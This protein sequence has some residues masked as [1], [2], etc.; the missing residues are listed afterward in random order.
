MDH[1]EAIIAASAALFIALIVAATPGLKS[2]LSAWLKRWENKLIQSSAKRAYRNGIERLA[3]FHTV[4]EQIR[5]L[6]W[7]DRVLVMVGKN[8]GGTPKPGKPYTVEAIHGWSQKPDAYPEKL[9]NYQMQIDAFYIEMINR[10]IKEGM[11]I[12]KTD[13]MP[14][15]AVLTALY[16]QENVFESITFCVNLSDHELIFLS[17]ASYTKSFTEGEI[18]KVLIHL[19]RMR[20][21]FTTT[22][23]NSNEN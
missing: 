18:A 17:V 10:M 21:I 7:V 16:K 13:G 2:I 5:D 14:A 15:N 23:A 4:L 1:I 3:E 12:N 9:Y 6:P 11:V 22:V 20:S 8:G 19:N